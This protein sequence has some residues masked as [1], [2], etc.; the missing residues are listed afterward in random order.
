MWWEPTNTRE[1]LLSETVAALRGWFLEHLSSPSSISFGI[2]T[3]FVRPSEGLFPLVLLD[4]AKFLSDAH[5]PVPLLDG[6]LKYVSALASRTLAELREIKAD[7]PIYCL[8][9]SAPRPSHW[10][11]GNLSD[12]VPIRGSLCCGKTGQLGTAGVTVWDRKTDQPVILTAGH[13]FPQGE[14]T[15]VLLRRHRWNRPTRFGR[16]SEHVVPSKSIPGWDAA[17]IEVDEPDRLPQHPDPDLMARLNDPLLTV[18]YGAVSGMIGESALIQGALQVSGDAGHTWENC[19]MLGPSGVL[20]SGDSGASVFTLKTGQ[21]VGTYVG[22]SYFEPSKRPFIHYVQDAASLEKAVL[23]N[24][25]I[26][27]RRQ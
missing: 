21:L 24:W 17:I 16:V 3:V 11:P 22:S 15:E 25:G 8:T 19:W 23:G 4:S 7:I 18:V 26:S 27:F 20:T 6:P 13:V 12:Y 5:G 1:K 14:N 2:G 10:S 9:V